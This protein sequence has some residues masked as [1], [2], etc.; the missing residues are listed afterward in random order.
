LSRTFVLPVFLA[1]LFIGGNAFS[2]DSPVVLVSSGEGTVPHGQ[3]LRSGMDAPGFVLKDIAGASFNFT[4]EKTKSPVLLVFF[5][6]FCEPCRRGLADAQR[7]HDRFRN[8]GLRVVAVALDGE[9][10]RKSVSG[11][12]R[13]ERY[14]FRVLIDEVDEHDRFRAADLF[15]VTGIP[16]TVLIGNGGRIVFVR[17]GAIPEVEV[18]KFLSTSKKP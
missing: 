8:A 9:S 10:F 11:F 15:G 5:S 12:V 3:L 14:G 2:Q 17:K 6:M 1:L 13:Q 7:L 16:T 4:A 18:E